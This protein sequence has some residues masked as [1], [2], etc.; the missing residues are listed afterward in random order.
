MTTHRKRLRSFSTKFWIACAGAHSRDPST[1]ASG[2]RSVVTPLGF[3][4]NWSS[5][6]SAEMEIGSFRF[7]LQRFYVEEHA[8]N[9]MMSLNVEDADAWRKY[10]DG[11]RLKENI[12][13]SWLDRQQCSLRESECF[14]S[15]TPRTSFGTLQSNHGPKRDSGRMLH[16]IG[17]R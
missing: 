15:M 10:I 1:D 9:F 8:T 4:T 3:K 11:I 2:H 16:S 13:L 6:D 5:E 14:I 7:L 12:Q 17:G